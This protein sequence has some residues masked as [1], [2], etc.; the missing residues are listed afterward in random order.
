M[1]RLPD[2]F[3]NF[4]ALKDLAPRIFPRADAG[5]DSAQMTRADIAFLL[6]VLDMAKPKKILEIGVAAGGSASVI[7]DAMSKKGAPFTMHSVDLSE[8]HYQDLS[9]RTGYLVNELCPEL[10]EHWTLLTGKPIPAVIDQIGDGVDFLLLD[11]AHILP[12][13]LL[14]F[15]VVLPHLAEGCHVVLHDINLFNGTLAADFATKVLFDSVVAE[16]FW[17]PEN[18]NGEYWLPNIG[19]FKITPDTRKY[20]D[21]C[22]SALSFPW[23]YVPEPQHIDWY[24]TALSKHY[25][26]EFLRIF[27]MAYEQNR[28]THRRRLRAAETTWQRLMRHL[29]GK[30]L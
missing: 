5:C 8:R 12:G 7:L 25:S 24:R 14:D 27:D 29:T 18:A 26:E 28:K 11:T 2:S 21:N 19:A 17:C 10:M 4:A 9:K 15:L 13:E 16:K 1:Q 20:I 30:K 3:P 6:G 23:E 22:F